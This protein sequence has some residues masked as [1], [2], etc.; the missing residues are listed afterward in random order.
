[1]EESFTNFEKGI[2]WRSYVKFDV[3]YNNVSNWLWKSFIERG[4]ATASKS[5]SS[6]RCAIGDCSL[7][8]R[9][10]LPCKETF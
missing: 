9:T 3:A 2:N 7:F 4:E 1:M 8:P 5:R 10:A 6:S